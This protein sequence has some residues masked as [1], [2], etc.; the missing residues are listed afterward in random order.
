MA[1]TR[2][3]KEEAL[4]VLAAKLADAKTTV[5]VDYTGIN[6]EAATELRRKAKEAGAEYLVAKKTLVSKAVQEQGV[7][8]YD[9]SQLHGNLG[10]L[11]G[12]ED[13]VAPAKLAKETSQKVESFNILAGIMEGVFIGQASVTQLADL[14][15]KEELLAKLVGSLNSPL[16]GMVGVLSGVQRQFVQALSA[17]ADQKQ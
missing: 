3:Q 1:K 10:I 15:S 4:S 8:G 9:V 14:P 2:A 11:L 7:E 16:S 12:Y 17:I 6:V 13:E 5:F